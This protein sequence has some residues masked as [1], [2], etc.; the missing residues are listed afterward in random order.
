MQPEKIEIYRQLNI[1]RDIYFDPNT[2]EWAGNLAWR[3]IDELLDNLN[4]LNVIDV[5]IDYVA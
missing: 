1:E 2:G 5:E 4:A 3:R